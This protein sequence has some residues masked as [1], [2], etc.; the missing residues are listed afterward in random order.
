MVLLKYKMEKILISYEKQLKKWEGLKEKIWIFWWHFLFPFERQ[1][2]Y[3]NI[4]GKRR[5]KKLIA[6]LKMEN[7][8]LVL[9][10]IK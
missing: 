3:K 9:L 5:P 2:H 1:I 6:T 7:E 8:L 4:S 10:K